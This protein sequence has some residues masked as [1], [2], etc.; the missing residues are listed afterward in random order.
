MYYT[1]TTLPIKEAPDHLYSEVQGTLTNAPYYAML[2][3]GTKGSPFGA[4]LS[5]HSSKLCQ[6]QRV[7]H[8]LAPATRSTTPKGPIVRD[9][10]GTCKDLAWHP[11]RITH[12]TNK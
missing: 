6:K 3:K 11:A 9:A 8:S 7:A 1:R 2:V 5:A 12:A 4:V 10:H